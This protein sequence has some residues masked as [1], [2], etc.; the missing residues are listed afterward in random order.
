MKLHDDQILVSTRGPAMHDL[1]AD[2]RKIVSTSGVVRGLCTV[3][4]QHTSASLV[5][6]ENAAPEVQRDLIRWLAE[7]APLGGDYEHDDEGA[8]DMPAHLKSALTHS[9]ETVPIVDGRLV[10]GRWQAV[11][12]LEHRHAPHARTVS[13]MI[14]GETVKA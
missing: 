4:L 3:F 10:L 2:L 6:Q 5:V 1:T 13:V 11:Y 7:L 8:D 9:N 14:I 12:L